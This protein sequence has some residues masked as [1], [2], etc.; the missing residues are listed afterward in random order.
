M[1]KIWPRSR[2]E[3]LFQI[4]QC[5]LHVV[6]RVF[7]V[8]D[9]SEGDIYRWLEWSIQSAKQNK[10]V[11]VFDPK[12]FFVTKLYSGH[13]IVGEEISSILADCNRI[14]LKLIGSLFAHRYLKRD[15]DL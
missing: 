13:R 9:A 7:G 11:N 2:F 5:Q 12:K 8:V 1:C 3:Y 15:A 14:D 4:D 6:N 10:S